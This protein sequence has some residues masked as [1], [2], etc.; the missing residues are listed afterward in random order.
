MYISGDSI[1]LQEVDEAAKQAN[2]EEVLGPPDEELRTEKVLINAYETHTGTDVF[3]VPG[4]IIPI[5]YDS[6]IWYLTLAFNSD[7]SYI[8]R[9]SWAAVDS[10]EDA[11]EKHLK[12]LA[13]EEERLKKVE[14]CNA[15]ISEAVNLDRESLLDL[16]SECA[17]ASAPE[18]RWMLT[19][20]LAHQ[21]DN[22]SQFDLGVSYQFG[23][24][25]GGINLPKALLWYTLSDPSGY[26]GPGYRHCYHKT[27]VGFTCDDP[28]DRFSEVRAG[29]TESSIVEVE[30][31]VA[32]WQPNPAECEVFSRTEVSSTHTD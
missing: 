7:G 19:C 11:I 15:A 10:T 24:A 17:M 8:G 25:P 27:E 5:P 28:Y 30:R 1:D 3:F 29:L 32:N 22:P 2:L 23:Q 13:S 12:A 14:E 21:E 18:E 16:K 4:T 26:V 20:L 9:R 6:D 31:Q